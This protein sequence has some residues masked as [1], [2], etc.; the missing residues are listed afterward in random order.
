MRARFTS[1]VSWRNRESGVS[2]VFS[3]I[4][5]LPLVIAL[6]FVLV[7][8]GIN[9]RYRMSVDMIVHDTVRAVASD[10]TAG[11][12][13]PWSSIYPVNPTPY[14]NSNGVLRPGVYNGASA[15]TWERIGQRKLESLC[16][17]LQRCTGIPSMKCTPTEVDAKLG[18]ET[19]VPADPGVVVRCTAYFPYRNL[20][21]FTVNNATFNLGFG[22]FWSR[23]IVFTA[24]S[25][26][27]VGSGE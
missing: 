6:I 16:N 5:V 14:A 2:E 21:N 3:T 7:E 8:V 10:G 20:V 26:T 22:T 19:W 12:P 25:R 9:M 23:P 15:P 11:V 4:F 18:S 17:G 13:P 27:L 1:L 24:Q